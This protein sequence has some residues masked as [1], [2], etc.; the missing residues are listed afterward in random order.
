MKLQ[1]DLKENSYPIYIENG[2]LEHA[3]G[4]LS[5]IFTGR[6]IMVISD[7]H[8]YPLYGKKLINSLDSWE[9]HTLVLPHGEPTKSF[10]TLSEVY[11]AML[12]ARI[13]RS[14]LVI[15]LGGGVIGMSA[16]MLLI[17][18]ENCQTAELYDL[19]ALRTGIAASEGARIPKGAELNAE[20]GG[21]DYV[22]MYAAAKYDV[23]IETTGAASVFA[24]AFRLVKPGGV[25]GSVGMME[26]AEIPQRLIVTKALTVLGSIGGTGD[27]DRSMEFLRDYPHAAEKLISHTFPMTRA[28]EAFSTA[29]NPEE[30]MKVVLSL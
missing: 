25:L 26:K 2:I 29:R 14:D 3:G 7:D 18:M 8:V 22:S 15:A 10:Q 9:C 13:S 30:S 23:V 24:N 17:H 5:Q 28:T 19:S 16:L 4:Y 20:A 1:V 12:E 21:T 27:F 11:S 6:K